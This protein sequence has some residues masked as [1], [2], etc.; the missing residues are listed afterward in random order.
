MKKERYLLKKIFITIITFFILMIGIGSKKLTYAE[1]IEEKEAKFNYETTI[2]WGEGWQK[3]ADIKF[4]DGV[5]SFHSKTYQ[6]PG[7]TNTKYPYY[8]EK[9]QRFHARGGDTIP[10]LIVYNYGIYLRSD[11]DS[12]T[13]PYWGK[14]DNQ[15]YNKDGTINMNQNYLD[16]IPDTVKWAVKN[17][18]AWSTKPLNI[19]KEELE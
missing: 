5:S 19:K 14:V 10:S 9:K 17:P 6:K 12:P 8:V 11:P 16:G 4:S 3:N 18:D 7:F 1:T 2:K 15:Q 13:K